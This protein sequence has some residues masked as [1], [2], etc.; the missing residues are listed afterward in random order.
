M[1]I[2]KALIKIQKRKNKRDLEVHTINNVI[3]P[4][5]GTP[6]K[7]RKNKIQSK[8]IKNKEAEALLHHLPP[9]VQPAQMDR[10]VKNPIKT[11]KKEKAIIILIMRLIGLLHNYRVSVEIIVGVREITPE[12]K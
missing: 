10:E 9:Q 2:T 1:I 7:T 8:M 12:D 11:T 3:Y 5:K 4:A 6:Q